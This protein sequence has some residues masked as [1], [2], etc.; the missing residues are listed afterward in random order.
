MHEDDTW[1]ESLSLEPPAGGL[2][3]LIAAVQAR[4]VRRAHT[5]WQTYVAISG[6]FAFLLAFGVLNYLRTAPQRSIRTAIQATLRAPV[7]DGIHVENGAAL[8]LPSSDP[9]VRVFLIASIASSQHHR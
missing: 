5:H 7:D 4:R 2:S 8:E 6:A 9:N 3:R 1:R